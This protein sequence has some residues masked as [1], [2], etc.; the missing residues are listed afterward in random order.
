[1]IINSTD[2]YRLKEI[3]WGGKEVAIDCQRKKMSHVVNRLFTGPWIL[4]IFFDCSTPEKE[5]LAK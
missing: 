3:K 5:T 4:W 1:M 2:S